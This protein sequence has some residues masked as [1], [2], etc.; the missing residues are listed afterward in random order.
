ML[1]ANKSSDV[2]ASDAGV[3]FRGR[4][5]PPFDLFFITA[6]LKDNFA[7]IRANSLP[8]VASGRLKKSGSLPRSKTNVLQYGLEDVP[9]AL[10]RGNSMKKKK[11]TS[12]YNNRSH[13]LTNVLFGRFLSWL[14]AFFLLG[15]SEPPA[16]NKDQLQQKADPNGHIMV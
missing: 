12:Q 2:L 9:P 11:L 16:R 3:S 7:V 10:V 8:F 6:P 1:Q 13:L 14:P 15:S 4:R 5:T